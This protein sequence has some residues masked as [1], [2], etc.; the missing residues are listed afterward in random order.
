MQK[1]HHLSSRK[2]MRRV[3]RQLVEAIIF[4]GLMEYEK[5]TAVSDDSRLTFYLYGK[6]RT[7]SCKGKVSAF[8][9]VR[10]KEG[11]IFTVNHDGSRTETSLE[12]LT[13]D[14]ISEPEKRSQLVNE[15][16][17]TIQLSTWNEAHLTQSLSRRI[18][19]FEELESELWEGHLYHPCYK[20]R[21]GFTLDDHANFGPEARQSFP[22]QWAAVRREK[23]RVTLLEDERDF[24]KRELGPFMLENLLNELH[25][26]GKSFEEYTFLPIHP[27]QVKAIREDL[28]AGDLYLLKSRGD[29]YRATQSVRTLW[30][31]NQPMKAHVK[32]SMNLI[33]T[34]SLRTLEAHSICAA[35]YISQWIS[36][37]V[38][39]DSFLHDQASMIVLKEY[40]GI[41][42]HSQE[43]GSHAK[44]GAIWREN[45]RLYMKEDEGA[46]PFTALPL[47]ERDGYP[48]I[49]DWLKCYGIEK[50]LKRLLE[51]SVIPVWHLLTAHGIAVEAHAQNMILLHK[52]GWPT[53]V[54]LRD[55][56]DS[57]EYTRDFLADHSQVP[58]FTKIHEKFKNAPDN[59]YFWMS[60]IEALRELV[61]DTLFVFHLSELSFLLEEQYGYSEEKFWRLTREAIAEHMSNY[62]ELTVRNDQLQHGAPRIYAESLFKKKVQQEVAGGFRH[63]VTNALA[64]VR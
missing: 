30:N 32:L 56:H 19:T 6:K 34:S 25:S 37:T 29:S 7:Y 54:A 40:A 57:T 33:H 20:S 42:F 15:L 46:V 1:P 41:A 3:I 44:L 4:E 24:W 23:A 48:F 18:S 38:E 28:D 21:T 27:W 13:E 8:D 43:E 53:R 35:P 9:R 22:L 12:E 62:P 50:W 60:S 58:D 2:I 36:K 16:M 17:Q 59:Q 55:F 64:S 31:T 39:E 26:I 51:V 63:F 47:M 45:I 14:L 52:N 49:D 11:T 5:W 10:V 61:M